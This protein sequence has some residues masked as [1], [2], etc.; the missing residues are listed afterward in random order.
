MFIRH[1]S[2]YFLRQV[3]SLI[4]ELIDLARLVNDLSDSAS[5]VVM[6]QYKYL[7]PFASLYVGVGESKLRFS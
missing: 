2:I 5:S 3:L 7:P 1:I 4:L 6:L